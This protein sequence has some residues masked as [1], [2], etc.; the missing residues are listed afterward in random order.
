MTVQGFINP[1]WFNKIANRKHECIVKDGK[2]VLDGTTL[3][4]VHEPAPL[5]DG[6]VVI[7]TGGSWFWASVKDELDAWHRHL[8]I[9]E[10]IRWMEEMTASINRRL[11]AEQFNR[12]FK[13]PVPWVAGQKDVLSGLSAKSW[14]DGRKANTVN[15]ILLNAPL[16]VGR[17]NRQAGDFLCTAASGTNGK[18]WAGDPE[19]IA[20]DKAGQKYSPKITCKQCLRLAERFKV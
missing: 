14:G 18:N 11:E 2:V 15:H 4:F 7:I 12:Q 13:L 5:P 20:V 3:V 17:L 10:G 6:T 1:F 8:H 16:K 19:A 9:L